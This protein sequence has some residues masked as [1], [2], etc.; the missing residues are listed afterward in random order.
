MKAARIRQKTC[1]HCTAIS[2]VLYRVQLGVNL[3]WVYLCPKCR[4]KAELEFAGY[5]YG[6]TWKAKKR[7]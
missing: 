5:R 1:D 7:H 3:P 4:T 2:L 6:G